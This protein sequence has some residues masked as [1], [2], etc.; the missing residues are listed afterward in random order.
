[1]PADAVASV[2]LF[3]N[4]LVENMKFFV[5]NVVVDLYTLKPSSAD[6]IHV[7]ETELG[8]EELIATLLT[9]A[10]FTNESNPNKLIRTPTFF[11]PD[12]QFRKLLLLLSYENTKQKEAHALYSFWLFENYQ[13]SKQ[14]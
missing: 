5:P 7:N 14:N 3:V 12:H 1:L 13:F 2:P 11:I 9:K 6:P 10:A 8:H 4:Q